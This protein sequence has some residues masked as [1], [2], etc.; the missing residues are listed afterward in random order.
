M[1]MSFSAGDLIWSEIK[2][3]QMYLLIGYIQTDESYV[4]EQGYVNKQ[5]AM[6]EW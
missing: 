6:E 4:L 2:S 1:Q 5:T 3:T